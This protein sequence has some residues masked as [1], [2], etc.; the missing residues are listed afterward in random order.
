M[1]IDSIRGGGGPP[2]EAFRQGAQQGEA[3]QVAVDGQ[4]FKVVAQGQMQAQGATGRSV[5]WVQGGADT[6]S[7]FIDAMAQSYGGALSG[8]VARELGLA[9]APGQPL[10][11]RTVTQALEMAGTGAQALAGV[12]FMTRLDHSAQGQGSAFRGVAAQLGLEPQA[13]DAS[14]RG[15]IDQRMQARFD[16]AAATGQSPVAAATASAW[17]REELAAL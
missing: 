10:A 5:A 6:T 2:I 9:P 12:D 14:Q 7:L 13:L 11:S 8:A 17:L 1:S 4:N 3:V 16:A 15:A